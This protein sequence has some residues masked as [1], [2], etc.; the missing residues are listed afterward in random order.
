MTT[1]MGGRGGSISSRSKGKQ[2]VS[3]RASNSENLIRHIVG[4]HMA[5]W[6]DADDVVGIAEAGAVS[7]WP[8]KEGN[9]TAT[10]GTSGK[11]PTYRESGLNS[12]PSV[13]FDASNDCLQYAADGLAS[14]QMANTIA[15][16]NYCNTATGIIIELGA[17]YHGNGVNGIVLG[18]STGNS[19][20]GLGNGSDS[21]ETSTAVATGSNSDINV[22]VATYDRNPSTDV[23]GN[24]ISGA[25]V[26]R[27]AS[28]FVNSTDPTDWEG[29]VTNIGSRDNGDSLPLAGDIRELI[30]IN[31]FLDAGEAFRLS[32]ALMSKSGVTRL[33]S[34]Y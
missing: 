12:R 7:S 3:D 33:L 19:W 30:I 1:G 21:Y 25:P 9:S 6:L 34:D 28:N 2:D 13:R 10:Q 8:A 15:S 27:N 18:Y 17:T 26:T 32:K 29:Q 4:P 5:T 24:Y 22:L 31:R 16:T 14:A 11:R 23:L 20:G